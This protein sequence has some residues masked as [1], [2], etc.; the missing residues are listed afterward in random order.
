MKSNINQQLVERLTARM[1][2]HRIFL[3]SYPVSGGDEQPHLLL[4]VNPVNGLAPKALA[5]LVSLCF[6]DTDP[7]SF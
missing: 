2:L 4:V 6:S 3:F 1:D 5:P 7:H